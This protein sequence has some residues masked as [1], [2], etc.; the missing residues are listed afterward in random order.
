MKLLY[1]PHWEKF[2]EKGDNGLFTSLVPKVFF[3]TFKKS[4]VLF[5]RKV[6]IDF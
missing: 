4:L 5:F 1:I 6:I 3:I 2:R